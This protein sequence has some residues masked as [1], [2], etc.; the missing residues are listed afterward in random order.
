MDDERDYKYDLFI[1]Y[2]HADEGWA[3]Q[4]AA[5]LERED[6]PGRRLHVFF[7]PWDIRPGE[8]IA[9]SLE[10]ALPRSRK[11]GLV[12]TPEAMRSEWVK[13]ERLV[14]AHIDAE[15]HQRRLIPLRRRPC[16]K[17]PALLL[18]IR[19]IDFEDD[20]QFEHGYRELLAAVRDEPLPR[21]PRRGTPLEVSL[22]PSIPRPPAGSF[23]ARYNREGLNLLELLRQELSPKKNQLV[24]LWGDGG[25]G[26]TT[27]AYEALREMADDFGQRVVWAS[28][29]LRANLTF[30][31]L[32]DEVATQLGH[33]EV[34]QL[35]P[36]PKEERVL[37][38]ID[39][40]PALVVLDNFETVKRKEQ[41]PCLDFLSN[42]ARCPALITTR[43]RVTRKGVSNVAVEVMNPGEAGEFIDNWVKREAG[44]PQ[45]FDEIDR[46]RIVEA[47][48][49]NP[50]VMQWVVA[51][52]DRARDPDAV[53]AD[54]SRGKG[55]AA[56][57]VFGNTFKLLDED[58]R[59]A[60]LALSLF[61]P[62]ASRE[63]LAEV[64]GLA[65]CGG[66]AAE[67]GEGGGRE[68]LR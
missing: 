63:A 17:L 7:A 46:G 68:V 2:Q 31:T 35:A 44:N 34:R 58:A 64:T 6:Y 18:G 38:L 57:R 26:K 48:G 41:K 62:G 52:I 50:L 56:A 8:H 49:R 10:E 16:E 30:G 53:L 40:A 47:A 22:P 21:G 67:F 29:E 65:G 37:Q 28:P 5:R 39:E 33:P 61:T 25:V 15:E 32:L 3:E 54:L 12:V 13:I 4:L 51:Q 20:A 55:D 42:R 66:C 19:A 14:T 9:E 43:K 60:L 27:L 45:V 23:V 24:V 36:A 59:R 1:S 11:V